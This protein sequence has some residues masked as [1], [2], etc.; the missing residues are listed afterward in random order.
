MGSSFNL[1]CMFIF[2]MDPMET[3]ND[4]MLSGLMDYNPDDIVQIDDIDRIN[5]SE[6]LAG[7]TNG[8]HQA[9]IESMMQH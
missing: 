4:L 2:S 5:V 8:M 7:A 9:D 3:P 6:L 1:E